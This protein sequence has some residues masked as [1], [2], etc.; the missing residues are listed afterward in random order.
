MS[1]EPESHRAPARRQVRV[2]SVTIGGGAPLAVIAGPCVIENRDSALRHAERIAA[3]ARQS[4][5]ALIYKSSFDK[6]NRTSGE[7]FRGPELLK[8]PLVAMAPAGRGLPAGA[9][10]DGRSPPRHP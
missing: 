5:V 7:S 2:G 9:R 6:A 4:G 8:K 10:R 3:I 1:P